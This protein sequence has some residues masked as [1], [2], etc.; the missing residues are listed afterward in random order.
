M[1]ERLYTG[2]IDIRNEYWKVEVLIIQNSNGRLHYVGVVNND[3]NR[4]VE[5]S[6]NQHGIWYDIK[7]GVTDLSI[8]LGKLIE[9]KTY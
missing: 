3:L 9:S 4:Y 8:A 2:L 7:R 5:V 6:I 1:E